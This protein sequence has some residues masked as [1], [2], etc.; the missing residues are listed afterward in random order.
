VEGAANARATIAPDAAANC[1]AWR[2]L[3][4]RV[5]FPLCCDACTLDMSPHVD[6]KGAASWGC[7]CPVGGLLLLLTARRCFGCV[8][9]LQHVA[10]K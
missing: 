7:S 4:E 1:A 9:M 8:P 10:G 5:E 6:I 3:T 2:C